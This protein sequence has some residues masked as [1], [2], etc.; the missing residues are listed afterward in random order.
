MRNGIFWP[1]ISL[2][3]QTSVA[4]IKGTVL[5]WESVARIV[6]GDYRPDDHPDI[7][8]LEEA[9]VLT[10]LEPSQ[11]GVRGMAPLEK[12]HQAFIAMLDD[13]DALRKLQDRYGLEKAGEWKQA[14]STTMASYKGD[15]HD[16][17]YGYLLGSRVWQ[18]LKRRLIAEG[19]AKEMQDYG[20]LGTHPLLADACIR[21]LA[22]AMAGEGWSLVT[23][24]TTAFAAGSFTL[25]TLR[26]ALLT[27]DPDQGPPSKRGNGSELIACIMEGLRLD[28]IEALPVREILRIRKK[29]A[30]VRQTFL[31]EIDKIEKVIAGSAGPQ[32][33]EI[34]VRAAL[35][36]R[37]EGP[38]ENLRTD[39]LKLNVGTGASAA[40]TFTGALLKVTAATLLPFDLGLTA[41]AA[42]GLALVPL[43]S[44][45]FAEGGPAQKHPMGYLYLLERDLSA[46]ILAQQLANAR[47]ER[48]KA[49]MDFGFL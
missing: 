32:Q 15:D 18:P 49:E 26:D 17:R 48:L 42:G 11:R 29:H 25:E 22:T 24:H 3:E 19:L 39:L 47:K 23:D 27:D 33:R 43:L 35:R 44:R 30:A 37:I 28:G 14:V 7:R 10:R 9:D 31:G 12:V 34:A 21:S 4:W 8:A 5:F 46:A 1:R 36:E 2:S 41:F 20:W 45:R 38:L 40:T 16:P 13:Q 6:P